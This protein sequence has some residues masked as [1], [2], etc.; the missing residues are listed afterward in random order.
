MGVRSTRSVTT[1]VHALLPRPK[2]VRAPPPTP[3]RGAVRRTSSILR[4]RRVDV[5][6]IMGGDDGASA[7]EL[8]NR[9][10]AGGSMKD[11]QLS[12]SQLRARH[13]VQGGTGADQGSAGGMNPMIIV[14]LLVLVAIVAGLALKLSGGDK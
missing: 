8:R 5:R 14:G 12:A 6:A 13:G 10:H 3:L 9:F 2:P 7:S 11:D 4:H 1:L